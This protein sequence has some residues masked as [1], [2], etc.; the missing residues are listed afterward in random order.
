M[1]TKKLRI[2]WSCGVKPFHE[3]RYRIGAKAHIWLSQRL[4]HTIKEQSLTDS[5]ERE[6]GNQD[7]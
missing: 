2:A 5:T 6:Y 1:K 3:H 7:D 4:A